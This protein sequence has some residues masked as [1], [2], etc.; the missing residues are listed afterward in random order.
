VRLDTP[1]IDWDEIEMVVRDAYR[2]IAP[3]KLAAQVS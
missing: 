2:I 1:E 3:A